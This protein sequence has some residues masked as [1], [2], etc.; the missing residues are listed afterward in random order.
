[1]ANTLFTW[2]NRRKDTASVCAKLDR[3][4]GNRAFHTVVPHGSVLTLPV[5]TSDHHIIKLLLEPQNWHVSGRGRSRLEPWWFKHEAAISL[6]E[7]NWA[8]MEHPTP[9]EFMHA[10]HT[11]KKTLRRWS[12]HTF[13]VIPKEIGNL[14]RQ[15]VHLENTGGTVNQIDSHYRKLQDL[16]VAEGYYWQ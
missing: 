3:A 1:M 15:I 8:T 9:R 4:F 11:L 6:V 16:T 14:R 12:H 13:G 7:M 2:W 5:Y 10:L